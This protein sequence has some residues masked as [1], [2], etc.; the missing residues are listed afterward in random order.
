MSETEG[1]KQ[2][3][4]YGKVGLTPFPSLA[5]QCEAISRAGEIFCL[6]S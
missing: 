1:A 2:P 4:I 5:S 3:E 6:E